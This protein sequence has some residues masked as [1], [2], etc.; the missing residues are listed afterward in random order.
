MK[1]KVNYHFATPLVG[2]PDEHHA[3]GVR[4]AKPENPSR[5]WGVLQDRDSKIGKLPKPRGCR[6]KHRHRHLCCASHSFLEEEARALKAALEK[7]A[8]DAAE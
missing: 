8:A 1:P 2:I 7:G 3:P 4:V 5:C 6:A